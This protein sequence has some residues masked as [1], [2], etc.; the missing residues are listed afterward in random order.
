MG[1]L[2]DIP[3]GSLVA[4]DTVAWIYEVEAHVHFGPIVHPFFRDRLDEGKNR[5]GSSLLALGELLVQPLSAG[6][7]DLADRYRQ[8]FVSG[9]G[10]Q[11]WEVTRSVVERAADLRARYRVKML[12][13]LHLASALEN[14]AELFVSNDAE[15]RR[16]KELRVV[17][18]SDYLTTG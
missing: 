3:E 2:D 10:F 1:L 4:L 18:L 9:G 6:R 17:I 8:F 15:L 11:V 14:E 13:A 16:V 5:A 12:D 7:K